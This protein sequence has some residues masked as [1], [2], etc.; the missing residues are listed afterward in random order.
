[1][2]QEIVTF[3]T[4]AVG[5]GANDRLMVEKSGFGVAFHAKEILKKATKYHI[6]YCPLSSLAFYLNLEKPLSSFTAEELS[7][8]EN[9]LKIE[10]VKKF[11]TLEELRNK[12]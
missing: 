10:D 7:L 4:I 1:M 5:D 9:F 6:N 11:A 3:Q 12:I 8:K 2:Q